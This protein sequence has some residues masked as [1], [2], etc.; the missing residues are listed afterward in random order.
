[1][2][3]VVGRKGELVVVDV[4]VGGMAVALGLGVTWVVNPAIGAGWL[5]TGVGVEATLHEVRLSTAN[6]KMSLQ[7]IFGIIGHPLH[8]RQVSHQVEDNIN[9]FLL[10]QN[11]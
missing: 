4:V 7:V 8:I 10:M 5:T 3:V 11:S 2:L 6:I 1:M 9:P